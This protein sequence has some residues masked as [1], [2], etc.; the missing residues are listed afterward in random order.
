MNFLERNVH[1]SPDLLAECAKVT[2]GQFDEIDLKSLTEFGVSM[3]HSDDFYVPDL[4]E[5][6]Y[7]AQVAGDIKDIV[8]GVIQLV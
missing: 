7:Y 6:A 4:S 8:L 1:E 3:R 5:T 2:A